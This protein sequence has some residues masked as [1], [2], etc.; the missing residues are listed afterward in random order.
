MARQKRKASGFDENHP[1]WPMALE[2]WQS[3]HPNAHVATQAQ[4]E[5]F[6]LTEDQ[7]RYARNRPWS[8]D[9]PPARG[10]T[11]LRE[12]VRDATEV[13]PNALGQP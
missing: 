3:G 4:A 8:A 7:V 12:A 1:F 2:L 5:G 13:Y 9:A 11:W 10:A 6:D